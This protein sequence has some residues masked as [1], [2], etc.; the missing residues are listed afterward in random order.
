MSNAPYSF[1]R[2]FDHAGLPAMS[3]ATSCPVPYH[4]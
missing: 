2:F 3:S 4:A 1:E